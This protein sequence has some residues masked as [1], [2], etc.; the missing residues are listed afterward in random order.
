MLILKK[1]NIVNSK[2]D[3][4]VNS[5][6]A[7]L[8]LRVGVISN[9]VL[10]AT[11]IEVENEVKLRYPNG[12]NYGDIAISSAGGLKGVKKLYHVACPK[13]ENNS[14]EAC[15]NVKIAH[16]FLNCFIFHFLN[17]LLKRFYE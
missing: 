15:K 12:I 4:I 6:T 10:N 17:F 5:C 9:C 11:G 7:H 1:G 3:V 13:F 8:E 16:F 2:V 14:S